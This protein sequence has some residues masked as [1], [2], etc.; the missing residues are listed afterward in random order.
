MHGNAWAHANDSIDRTGT[1]FY[2]GT[3]NNY[4]D[5]N[6]EPMVLGQTTFVGPDIMGPEIGFIDR[7]N[8][9]PESYTQK[10]AILKFS[11]GGSSL[12]Y[13]WNTRVDSNNNNIYQQ[14]LKAFDD[15]TTKLTADG[16]TYN[17]KGMVWLQ[18][19]SDA[20]HNTSAYKEN[21]DH[22]IVDIRAALN[23][24]NLPI[25]FVAIHA[26][27]RDWVTVNN[28]FQ[29]AAFADSNIGFVQGPW[30]QNDGLHYNTEGITE[31]GIAVA[32]NMLLAIAGTT[33]TDDAVD[34]VLLIKQ[35]GVPFDA[36]IRDVGFD[37]QGTYTNPEGNP[38]ANL[39]INYEPF[40]D[41]EGKMIFKLVYPELNVVLTW[42]QTSE[43]MATSVT[44]FEIDTTQEA[45]HPAFEGLCR[46]SGGGT[47]LSG[48]SDGGWYWA[49]GCTGFHR[50]R[51]PGLII[52]EIRH[53]ISNLE[54]YILPS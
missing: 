51:I 13:D 4:V 46:D 33:P 28:S 10:I 49:T 42:K 31:V 23:V 54:F 1:L 19:E 30:A 38:Y 53:L 26:H 21:L 6:F 5:S 12:G 40:K 39:G 8:A 17:I 47:L 52:G 32:D 37:G 14:F 44:G 36:S 2:K 24:P 15:A 50:G 43:P 25:V 45:Y 27:G 11:R 20:K 35:Y 29:S 48:Q 16:Y 34:P 7:V 41:S 18:G 22:L 3:E 9:L